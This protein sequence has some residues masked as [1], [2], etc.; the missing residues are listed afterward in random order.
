MNFRYF[1]VFIVIHRDSFACNP[2]KKYIKILRETP[3]LIFEYC[4]RVK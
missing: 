1:H 4:K 3:I 2:Y